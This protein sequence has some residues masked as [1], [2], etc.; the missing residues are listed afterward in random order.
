MPPRGWAGCANCA[1]PTGGVG[2][3]V[4]PRGRLLLVV[5]FTIAN[6]RIVKINAVGAPERLG[7]FDLAVLNQ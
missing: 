5:N 2:A 6:G 1:A 3:V 7:A 4:A